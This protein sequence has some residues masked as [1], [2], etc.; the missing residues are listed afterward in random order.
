VDLIIPSI[1]L[2]ST[3]YA[4]TAWSKRG[5]WAAEPCPRGT[6]V[7][8]GIGCIP[9]PLSGAVYMHPHCMSLPCK[10]VAFTTPFKLRHTRFQY[11]AQCSLST[12]L[13]SFT[14]WTSE[15]AALYHA[16]TRPRV[17]PPSALTWH[18]VYLAIWLSINWTSCWPWT[19]TPPLLANRSG[20]GL[21][22][23]LPNGETLGNLIISGQMNPSCQSFTALVCNSLRCQ[24][25]C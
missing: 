18:N 7:I 20:D 25:T 10:S 2:L 16:V 23:N 3:V 19:A 4:I 14:P 1:P 15:E 11:P 9:A 6:N 22:P 21:K 24:R 13:G 17:A 5:F 12:R 8:S